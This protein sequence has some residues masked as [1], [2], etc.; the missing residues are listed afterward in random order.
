M[1]NKTNYT[2]N[3]I[4]Y[5]RIVKVVG[6]KLNANG[7][8]V[9][10][11]K[12]FLGKNKKEA[13]AK[14][15][16]YLDMRAQ[17]CDSSKQYFGVMAD[18]WISEFLLNE[19]E[20]KNTTIRLYVGAWNNYMRPS[21]IYSLPLNEVTS[22]LI[23][24][25]FNKLSKEGCPISQIKA[26]KKTLNKFY[27]YLV[28]NGYVPYD[29]TNSL[30]IPKRKKERQK[31]IIVWTDDE[32]SCILNNF[33]KAKSEFRL[34]FFIILATYTGMRISELRG[35]KYEDIEK[36]PSG[37]VLNVRRQISINENFNEEGKSR[38]TNEIS[39][40]KS[41]NS[42]RS[43]P[44]TSRVVE[45]LKIHRKWHR[46]EQMRKGYRTDYIFTT[47]SGGFYDSANINRALDRYYKCIGLNN[48]DSRTGKKKTCH[49]YRRTFGTNLYKKGVPILTACKLM[50]HSDISVTAKYYIGTGEE[51]KRK[52]VELLENIV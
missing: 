11:R 49:T 44:L 1:A 35:V 27:R 25:L 34:R 6:H 2:K 45:E 19:G 31:Q 47:E 12:E 4:D 5:Y 28:N 15:Q 42:Y 51:E 10:V 21:D 29:F 8:E 37:Y 33:N 43:I 39:S 38:F 16:A 7:I 18:R 40:L 41:E 22:G 48:I 36:T 13:E 26:V 14:L 23:Q 52:A 30:T 20:L 24:A 46:V 50:G 3:G 32:L 17:N 9:P